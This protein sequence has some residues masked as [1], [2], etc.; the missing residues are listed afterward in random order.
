MDNEE[1]LEQLA[2]IHLPIE[3]SYW[4]PAPGWW[5]LSLIL[6]VGTGFMVRRYVRYRSHKKACNYALTQLEHCR[7]QFDKNSRNQDDDLMRIR[8]VNS[9]N[10]V[11]RRV[12]LVHFPEE[13]VAS[14]SG[15]AWVDFIREKGDSSSL[16]ED[17]SSALSFGRFQ[18]KC[19]VDINDMNNLG[20]AW[21][22]SLYLSPKSPK[23]KRNGS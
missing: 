14:L 23:A 1:L 2:D 8:Y 11:L 15:E 3:I 7:V 20:R 13:N 21:I 16:D 22:S 5:L 4:P 9:F 10:S 17:I 18:T 19:N 6:I 12:A